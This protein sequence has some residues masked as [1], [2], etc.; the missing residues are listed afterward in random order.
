MVGR[1]LREIRRYQVRLPTRK[2]N[3]LADEIYSQVQINSAFHPFEVDKY[4]SN[5][6]CDK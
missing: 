6:C 2:R 3:F 5:V 4:S 1:G